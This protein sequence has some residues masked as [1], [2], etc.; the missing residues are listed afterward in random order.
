MVFKFYSLL[1]PSSS[2]LPLGQE[3][4]QEG[5]EV[6]SRP[7]PTSRPRRRKSPKLDKSE[8]LIAS[9]PKFDLTARLRSLKRPNQKSG[10][11]LS[12][13]VMRT[14]PSAC[15][16]IRTQHLGQ[17]RQAVPPRVWQCRDVRA[18]LERCRH[19]PRP[20]SRVKLSYHSLTRLRQFCNS[21]PGGTKCH[22]SCSRAAMRSG[23]RVGVGQS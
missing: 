9:R 11:F 2:R 23:S 20:V 22:L 4:C 7:R 10:R 8:I 21:P 16:R 14:A 13:T 17:Y 12:I 5:K 3:E 1:R 18:A 15:L 19:G 6:R